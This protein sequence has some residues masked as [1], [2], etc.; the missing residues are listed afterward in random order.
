MQ[1]GAQYLAQTEGLE[2]S[3]K[4]AALIDALKLFFSSTDLATNKNRARA[5]S[6]AMG[7]LNS[8][9]PNDYEIEAFYVLSLLGAADPRDKSYLNQH[10]AG[11][12]LKALKEAHPLHPGILH[13]TIHAYDF[14]G[15]AD[16]ALEEAK[17]YAQSAGDSAHAQ[18]MPSHIFTRLG[19]WE[20]SLSSNHDSIRS[21]ADYTRHAKL[22]GHYDEGLH[23]IDYL[24]YAMLQTARYDEAAA[25]L[26]QLGGIKKTDTENFKVA[27]TYAASPARYVWH[28]MYWS[29]RPGQRPV[30]LRSCG[31]IFFGRILVGRSLSITLRAASG[32]LAVIN[33]TRPELN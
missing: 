28:A 15:L 18:H 5:F 1:Q 25:L 3:A 14:P 6:D 8:D 20:L 12:L 9:Y 33:W 26:E 2:K 21:A 30:S 27:F 10:K 29:G 7:S 19:L 16:L 24:M 31:L 23:S 17:V 4:E 22:P 32:R 11:S 13:Y